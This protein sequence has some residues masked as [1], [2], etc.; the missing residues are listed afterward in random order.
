MPRIEETGRLQSMGL[1]RFWHD[2][3]TNTLQNETNKQTNKK[4]LS[5]PR[6]WQS[7]HHCGRAFQ[8]S[9][10][11]ASALSPALCSVRS[12]PWWEKSS[13]RLQAPFPPP[14]PRQNYKKGNNREQLSKLKPMVPNLDGSGAGSITGIYKAD[15]T[16]KERILRTLRGRSFR[17]KE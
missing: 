5:I 9:R 6:R 2:W 4:P 12:M 1:Q 7:A 15:F 14:H 16:M 3:A 8:R 13:I 17:H 10:P 11:C